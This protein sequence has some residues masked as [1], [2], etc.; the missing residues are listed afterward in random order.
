MGDYRV[1]YFSLFIVPFMVGLITPLVFALIRKTNLKKETKMNEDDFVMSQPLIW[2][3][4]SLF[5]SIVSSV[6]LIILNIFSDIQM[7]VN[8]IVIPFIVL[9]LFGAFV[10]VRE[11]IVVKMDKI[12]VTPVFGKTKLF[13]FAEIKVL[14][15]VI[16]SN[17]TISYKVYNEKKM[18]SISNSLPGYNLFMKRVMKANIKIETA[19]KRTY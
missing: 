5:A 11:K 7:V 6:I 9:F 12:I 8:L 2:V 10:F 17:G 18:F 4:L 14:K 1:K 3:W 15:E 16:W 19:N 13:S